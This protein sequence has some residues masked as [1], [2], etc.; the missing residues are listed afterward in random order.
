[1]SSP[2]FESTSNWLVLK[3]EKTVDYFDDNEI[4]TIVEYQY[5]NP[6]HYQATKIMTTNSDGTII[7]EKRYYPYDQAL[8]SN[9]SGD[10]QNG[11]DH[12]IYR[13]MLTHIIQSETYKGNETQLLG[14]KRIN[15]NVWGNNMPLV[16]SIQTSKGDGAL[17]DRIIYH[18]YDSRGNPI[19]VSKI[20]GTHIYY[21]WGYNDTQPIAKIEN[22][23]TPFSSD[24]IDIIDDAKIAS[25]F[26]NDRTIDVILGNGTINYIGNEG[27]L[28]YRLD[29]LR[30]YPKFE[31]AMITTYTY[32]PLIG[33]TSVTDPRG[34]VRYYDYDDFNR[35]KYVKDFKGNILSKNEYH[36]KNQ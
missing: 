18:D 2:N 19:E 27:Q 10:A 9:L 23:T 31:N 12:L 16:K 22:A 1:M 8:L 6:Q 21:I 3:K 5:D 24:I 15:Y 17:E 35:L 30:N 36:Y 20:D 13:H 11:I 7:T 29:I 33:V 4:S 28:R 32:D 26:D 34:E 14:T 25:N